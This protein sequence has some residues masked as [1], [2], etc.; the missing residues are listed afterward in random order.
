VSIYPCDLCHR[1]VPGS[2]EST[3][4]T[5]LKGNHPF[6]RR[7]RLCPSHLSSLLEQELR[8]MVELERFGLRTGH[9]VCDAC[10]SPCDQGSDQ[11]SAFSWIYRRGV[12]PQELGAELCSS[13]GASLIDQLNLQEEQYRATPS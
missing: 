13:C 9:P 6:T 10:G 5:V 8:Y 11:V 7:L 1:R 4:V 3:R 2:L 12:D